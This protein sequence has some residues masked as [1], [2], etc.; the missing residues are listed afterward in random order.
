MKPYYRYNKEYTYEEVNY[1]TSRMMTYIDCSNF[2]PF[3]GKDKAILRRGVKMPYSNLLPYIRAIGKIITFVSFVL[4]REK[5]STAK[6]YSG[7]YKSKEQYRT[8][9][10]FSVIFNIINNCHKNW[11]PNCF[12]LQEKLENNE[13]DVIFRPFTFF[14][15]KKVDVDI[16]NY[17][18]DIYLETI[19]KTE[20]LEEKIKLGKSIIYN[21]KEKI[22]EVVN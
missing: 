17:T 12:R 1:V 9:K 21:E 2:Y 14:F 6:N 15:V 18:A 5:E 13:E 10:I 16:N 19:G 3:Y 8:C 11:I 7:R 20:I 4:T 22:M